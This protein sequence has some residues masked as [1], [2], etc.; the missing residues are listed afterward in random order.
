MKHFECVKTVQATEMISDFTINANEYY[1]LKS[2]VD[3]I[4]LLARWICLSLD[5]KDVDEASIVVELRD[6]DVDIH[7]CNV[8]LGIGDY[9]L[10]IA[11]ED[12]GDD[13]LFFKAGLYIVEDAFDVEEIVEL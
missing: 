1:E 3:F 7:N 11:R 10:A 13:N 12:N 2:N 9:D 8:R 5:G 6:N 4:H